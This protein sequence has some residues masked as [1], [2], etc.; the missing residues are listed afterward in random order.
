MSNR[1]NTLVSILFGFVFNFF[2]MKKSYFFLGLV[3][4]LSPS[5]P[6]QESEL[7]TL[8]WWVLVF[9]FG[10]NLNTGIL[11][12]LGPRWI[13]FAIV[14]RVN[15]VRHIPGMKDC[16]SFKRVN[17]K[18]RCRSHRKIDDFWALRSEDQKWVFS[19]SKILF[20]ILVSCR[21]LKLSYWGSFR[22][23]NFTGIFLP[24]MAR[25]MIA[26][27][28]WKCWPTN[29]GLYFFTKCVFTALGKP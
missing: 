15:V 25:K 17:M 23:L 9:I 12:W 11:A 29:V 22:A 27:V 1:L 4:P 8:G 18:I 10:P 21:A 7:I 5:P 2:E 19:H 26:H 28:L 24:E 20:T 13:I 3:W 6:M 16:K 14:N